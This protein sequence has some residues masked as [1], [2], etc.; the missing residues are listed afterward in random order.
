MNARRFLLADRDPF[1][2]LPP[3]SVNSSA[4]F[5]PMTGDFAA[6]VYKNKIYPAILGDAGPADKAGE[7][8]LFIAKTLNPKANGKTRVVS[9]V[10]VSYFVFPKSGITRSEPDLKVWRQHVLRLL[11]E[12]GGVSDPSAVHTWPDTPVR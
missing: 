12:I 7:A 11:E 4:A 1:V 9:D 6:V 8:S 5:G 3:T 2:V 10:S